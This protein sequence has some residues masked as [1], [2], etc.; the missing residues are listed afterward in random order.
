MAAWH[1][2]ARISRV[3][4]LVL[5]LLWLIDG[6]LQFQP[7]MFG[8]TFIT[9]VILPSASG[10]PGIIR[11]PIAWIAGLIEPR[12]AVFNALAATLQV[13]IG[14]G[15]LYR[16]TVKPALLV[17][18]FWA[19]SIW[20]AGE[21][22]GMLFTGTASPLT[23]APGAALLYC[24]VGLM[25]WPPAAT[26]SVSGSRLVRLPERFGEPAARCAWAAI[27]LGSAV[28][29][30]L[31]ANDGAEAA[32]DA[33]VAVP[34]GAGWLSNVLSSAAKVTAGRGTTIAIAMATLSIAI[35][36]SVVCSWHARLFLALAIVISI[37]YWSIGQGLG[38]V[39]T[40][41]ATDVGTAPVMILIA[42]I[43]FARESATRA[44]H[45]PTRSELRDSQG[46]ARPVSVW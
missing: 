30:L 32:H 24:L 40:G 28:L 19:T 18:F 4:Q 33:I 36:V 27:W 3:G 22:L 23:G 45:P 14:V 42:S 34:S 9:G 8:R 31:P 10:Q 44:Q 21:G 39:F 17:S 25:C 29:W 46:E 6:A 1:A 13:V 37:G 5:G 43:C 12:V 41:Q 15:L 20:F 16:R 35:G 26:I 38:G 2:A 7:Y 11:T